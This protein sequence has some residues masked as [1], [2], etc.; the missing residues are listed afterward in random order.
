MS[1]SVMTKRCV[2]LE[3]PDE[4]T[5]DNLDDES[6][7]S[8]PAMT[9]YCH[10]Q[11]HDETQSEDSAT[12]SCST[13]CCDLVFVSLQPC[14]TKDQ[15]IISKTKRLQGN[16]VLNGMMPTHGYLGV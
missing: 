9:L 6:S 13:L 14:Q 16:S 8:T 15:Q 7:Q 5:G 10:S 12:I 2:S 1:Y 11:T 4:E 3:N